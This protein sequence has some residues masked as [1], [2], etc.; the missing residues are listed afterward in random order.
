VAVVCENLPR[1]YSFAIVRGV[2]IIPMISNRR[3]GLPTEPERT[4]AHSGCLGGR[5]LRPTLE[6][7]IKSD[8]RHQQP[9]PDLDVRDLA[10]VNRLV[11]RHPVDAAMPRRKET[12]TVQVGL[13]VKE[14]LRVALEQAA[15]ERGVSMN[16]EI[17]RRLERSFAE[18]L[19]FGS[20]E[21]RRVGYLMASAFA[22]AGQFNAGDK[23]DWIKDRDCYRAG[24]I[25]VVDA[26][27]IG[28]PDA[29]HEDAALII[30]S[31]KG[32]LLTRMMM[33]EQKK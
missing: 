7:P 1:A 17:V 20:A 18:E 29:T 33:Q 10:G 19:A 9:P 6:Q 12:E 27:L 25:G 4:R 31:L 26:L 13:R 32:R 23:Q 11:R 2:S 21:L 24:L 3:A 5:L 14:S 28:L 8:L 16:A 15:S 30:E 22:M